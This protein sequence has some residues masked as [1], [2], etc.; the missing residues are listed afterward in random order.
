MS[1]KVTMAFLLCVL[2]FPMIEGRHQARQEKEETAAL[3]ESMFED[4]L[5]FPITLACAGTVAIFDKPNFDGPKVFEFVKKAANRPA[6]E[7]ICFLA[8][9]GAKKHVSNTKKGVMRLFVYSVVNGKKMELIT[10]DD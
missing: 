8:K 9:D 3:M 1:M 7:N 5:F 6:L 4:E 10:C 2:V